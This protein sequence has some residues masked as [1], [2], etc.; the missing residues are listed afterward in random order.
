MTQWCNCTDSSIAILCIF[1]LLHL[2]VLYELLLPLIHHYFSKMYSNK[3]IRQD[4]IRLEDRQKD[5]RTVRWNNKTECVHSK[6]LNRKGKSTE[7]LRRTIKI[8][9]E[10]TLN[11]WLVQVYCS[12]SKRPALAFF[13]PLRVSCCWR[14]CS[15]SPTSECP[16]RG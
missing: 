6:Q 7:M 1:C 12:G 9:H 10:K 14:S 16:W 4:K 3:K 15:E 5:M 11:C 2:C 13:H 8:G